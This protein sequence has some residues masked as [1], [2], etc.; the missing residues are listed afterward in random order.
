MSIFQTLDQQVQSLIREATQKIT[1]P[2]FYE[3]IADN[4]IFV[5]NDHSIVTQIDQDVQEFLQEKLQ[6]LLPESGFLGEEETKPT[7]PDQQL[8]EWLWIL[9]PIDG[10]HNFAVQNNDFGTMVALWHVPSHRPLYGWIYLPIADV[11]FSGGE[12]EGVFLNGQ[13]LTKPT[14]LQ[15]QLNQMKG[16]LN[17]GSFGD[18]KDRMQENSGE[19]QTIDPSSCA[20]VK[21]AALLQEKTDFAVFGRAKIWDLSAGFALLDEAGGYA[22]RVNGKPGEGAHDLSLSNPTSY[23]AWTLAVREKENWPM[24]RGQLFKN[25]TFN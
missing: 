6:T 5:K 8:G 7:S 16:L 21:F 23:S 18:A 24:I 2:A 11:M 19:F 1:L 17:Y 25:V 22:A 10:T 9:D 12:G 4:L 3:R 15:K 20:A 13:S 14:F